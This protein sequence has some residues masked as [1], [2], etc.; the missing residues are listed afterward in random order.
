MAGDGI[1]NAQEKELIDEVFGRICESPM[2]QIYDMVG[3]EIEESDYS[4]V[5]SFIKI[6]NIVAISFLYYVL[7]FAY[8]DGIIEDNV[9]ERLDNLFGI[10]LLAAFLQND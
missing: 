8:I 5:E 7:S 4:V 10:N 6:G 9:D 3:A 1:I 2:E